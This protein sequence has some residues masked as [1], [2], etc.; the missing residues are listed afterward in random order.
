MFYSSAWS[1]SIGRGAGALMLAAST[2]VASGC[3]SSQKAEPSVASTKEA[4]SASAAPSAE[5]A[6]PPKPEEP[7]CF[8][9]ES[10]ANDYAHELMLTVFSSAAFNQK[11][12]TRAATPENLKVLE[13]SLRQEMLQITCKKPFADDQDT[14]EGALLVLGLMGFDDKQW[15]AAQGLL[16][17]PQSFRVLPSDTQDWLKDPKTLEELKALSQAQAKPAADLLAAAAKEL[18]CGKDSVALHVKS[19]R[20]VEATGCKRT[21]VLRDDGGWKREAP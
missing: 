6:A 16:G 14:V 10:D 13:S 20:A 2:L 21:A 19:R 9:G 4:A 18:K 15:N 8:L 17:T 1:N 7:H 11:R 12:I 3:G 5:P